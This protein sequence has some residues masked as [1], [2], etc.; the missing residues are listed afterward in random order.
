ME[1]KLVEDEQEAEVSY[2]LGLELRREGVNGYDSEIQ[3]KK[4]R[5]TLQ[6]RLTIKQVVEMF[7]KADLPHETKEETYDSWQEII[8]QLREASK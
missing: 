8:E 7:D 2:F 1:L 6:A 4:A 5:R 3:Q